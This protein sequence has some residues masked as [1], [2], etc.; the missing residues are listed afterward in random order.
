VLLQAGQCIAHESLLLLTALVVTP[1]AV[2]EHVVVYQLDL[3]Q[4]LCQTAAVL[5]VK[6]DHQT[7]CHVLHCTMQV[8]LL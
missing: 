4:Q 3:L 8:K 1:G 6:C 2:G 7:F 5:K